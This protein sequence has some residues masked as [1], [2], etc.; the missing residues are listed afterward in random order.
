MY[1]VVNL[2]VPGGWYMY[3]Y[4]TIVTLRIQQPLLVG[5][6]RV[7]YLNRENMLNYASS[8]LEIARLIW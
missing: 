1:L 6:N 4:L 3:N 8:V 2:I 7:T 5:V